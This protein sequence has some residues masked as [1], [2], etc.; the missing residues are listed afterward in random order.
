M[1]EVDLAIRDAYME[2][3]HREPKHTE[4]EAALTAIVAESVKAKDSAAL[5]SYLDSLFAPFK[6]EFRVLE[7]G[8]IE[9]QVHSILGT[10]PYHTMEEW[11]NASAD[12]KHVALEE[13][14]NALERHAIETMY[15]TA[16]PNLIVLRSKSGSSAYLCRNFD[17]EPLQ[18][19]GNW[20]NVMEL[21][22]LNE[23]AAR[24]NPV[25]E[26]VCT[27]CFMLCDRKHNAPLI[28][29]AGLFCGD[30]AASEPIQFI[31]Q[32]CKGETDG[33]R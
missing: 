23:K 10:F 33:A 13:I 14:H 22:A 19:L 11:E 15:E 6:I 12:D 31:K 25:T 28:L 3:K 9:Y 18:L 20:E 17:R 5:V 2:Q 27:R 21:K 32:L 1:S 24:F 7:S 16:Y 30:C 4:M 29:R 26:Y 8:D